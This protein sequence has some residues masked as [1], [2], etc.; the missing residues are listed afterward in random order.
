M[1]ENILSKKQFKCLKKI[2]QQTVAF[3]TNDISKECDYLKKL[4]F[5]DIIEL[6]TVN[7][8]VAENR[9]LDLKSVKLIAEIKE[10]GKAYVDTHTAWFKKVRW[11]F[12][13]SILA[14]MISLTGVII[15]V[16]FHN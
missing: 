12:I 14:V 7:D 2:Y 16:I 1:N 13:I 5:I 3:I 15:N 6:V 10:A 4:D 11:D 9:I 8:F